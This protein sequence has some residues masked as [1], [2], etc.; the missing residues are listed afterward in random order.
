MVLVQSSWSRIS[1]TV[2]LPVAVAVGPASIIT[3]L[4]SLLGRV[5]DDLLSLILPNTPLVSAL[6]VSNTKDRKMRPRVF[7]QRDLSVE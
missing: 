7:Y 4:Q 1:L 2:S 6:A 5:G 3:L